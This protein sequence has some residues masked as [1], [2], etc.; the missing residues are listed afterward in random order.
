MNVMTPAELAG[1]VEAHV[2]SLLIDHPSLYREMDTALVNSRLCNLGQSL[3]FEVLA[4]RCA[5]ADGVEWL[6]DMVWAMYEPEHT[7]PL[8]SLI[9]NKV[10]IKFLARQAMVMEFGVEIEQ[11]GDGRQGSR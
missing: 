8:Q 1:T 2:R 5:S 4:S 7:L 10:E 11:A 3:G 9:R 6:Y